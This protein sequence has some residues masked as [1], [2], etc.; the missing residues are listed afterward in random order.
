M[1]I[2]G[3]PNSKKGTCTR[4]KKR[5]DKG[6][7]CKH[8]NRLGTK[9]GH[10]EIVTYFVWGEVGINQGGERQRRR[11]GGA[12]VGG[13]NL[14]LGGGGDCRVAQRETTSGELKRGPF[15]AER[16]GG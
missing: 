6:G 13:E 12:P 11:G 5:L 1:F 4:G 10:R 8:R 15:S 7:T 3:G 9:G 14:D 2:Q 16:L